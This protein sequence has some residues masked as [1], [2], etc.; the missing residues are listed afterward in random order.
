MEGGKT[1]TT[2]AKQ[3]SKT[4]L[5][6]YRQPKLRSRHHLTDSSVVGAG[7]SVISSVPSKVIDSIFPVNV[8]SSMLDSPG[9]L[10]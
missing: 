10:S 8:D 9:P 1:S 3:Q 7:S 5:V 2:L 6:L 4:I